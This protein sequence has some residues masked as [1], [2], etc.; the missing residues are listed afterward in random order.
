MKKNKYILSIIFIGLYV[1]SFAQN[2]V[3][4]EDQIAELNVLGKQILTSETDEAKHNV[5]AKYNTV[6]KTLIETE[7]SFNYNFEALKTISILQ[8]NNLKIYNWAVPLTDGTY[9]YYGYLQIKTGKDNYRVV[10]LV[11][12]SENTKLPETRVLTNKNWYGALYYKIIHSK[13]LGNDTYTL[14]GWDG[15]NLLTNKKIIDV[16]TTSE[17]GIIKFGASI[18]KTEKKT[19]KRII[20]E[21]AENVVMSLKY[22]KDIEKIVFDVLAPSNSSLKGIYEYYGPSLETFDAFYMDKKKWVYEKDIDIKLDPNLKDN[23]WSDPKEE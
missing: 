17:K 19:K 12:K 4:F 6:L 18:F 10:E 23:I 14:L 16:V 2:T 1:F 22:H 13:K 20:F 3:S 8:A 5:N 15:N 21:Y 11:D 9:E 7:N